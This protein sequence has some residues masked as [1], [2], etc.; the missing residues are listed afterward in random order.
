MQSL[1]TASQNLY[2]QKKTIFNGRK[3]KLFGVTKD[4]KL[5]SRKEDSD[6]TNLN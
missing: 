5:K 2:K 1:A 6:Y 4:K 3:I